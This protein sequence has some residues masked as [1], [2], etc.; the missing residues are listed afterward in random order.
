MFPDTINLMSL[1]ENELLI[2]AIILLIKVKINLKERYK[3]LTK[4]EVIIIKK[5]AI[6]IDC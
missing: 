6:V 3:Y 5:F 1:Q 2:I 4:Y